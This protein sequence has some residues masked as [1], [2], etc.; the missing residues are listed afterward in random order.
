MTIKDIDY[1]NN[2]FKYLESSKIHGELTTSALLTLHNEV[3]SNAQSI[4]TALGGGSNSHLGL[5]CDASTYASIPG[6]TAYVCPTHPGP[7]ALPV[8]TTQF[9]I[10]HACKQHQES[11][12]LFQEVTNIECTL[13]Q[14]IV[15]AIDAK[16]LTAIRNP[17][18]NKI[19]QTILAIFTYLFDAYGDISPA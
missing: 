17:V 14:Q 2:C 5:I 7:L 3:H 19:S 10:A 4:N 6:T 16:D 13:I 15:K 1:K 9:Q 12:C 18:T 8:P 11:L